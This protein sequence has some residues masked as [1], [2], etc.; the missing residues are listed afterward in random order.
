MKTT[1]MHF[2]IAL[3]LALL[4]SL[5]ALA[6]R[7]D[8]ANRR[9]KNGRAEGAAGGAQVVVEYGRPSVNGRAIWGSLVPY[10]KVWRTGADEAT[11]VTVDRDVLVE[12]QRL[13]AG[14][15]ALFTIPGESSW[16]VIFNQV[17][18]QW[19]AFDYDAG[20]DVLR[21]EVTPRAHEHVETFEIAVE[22]DAVVLRWAELEVPIRLTAAG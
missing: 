2:A 8:D 3:A 12:G 1:T 19:G 16:T 7:G 11:T 10:G 21:V 9:S 6:Q 5:P 14:T 20:Q 13:P 15:Y 22:D 17:A 18:K 4:T